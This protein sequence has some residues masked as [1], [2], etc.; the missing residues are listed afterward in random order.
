MGID[1]VTHEPLDGT[2]SPAASQSVVTV[3]SKSNDVMKQQRPQ[4]DARDVST[5]GSSSLPAESSTN[6][7]ST[8]G[9]SS[10]SHA[11]DPLVK[12]LLEEDLTTGDEPWLNFAGNVDVD[13]FSSIAADPASLQWDGATD[14]LLDY[15]DYVLGDS[16]LV[17]EYMVNSS[18]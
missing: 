2:G 8:G 5:D 9:S 18:K 4:D 11:Q 14:W 3:E 10:S 12:W 13:E 15:Q 1:P 6:T 17:D 16:S 7:S